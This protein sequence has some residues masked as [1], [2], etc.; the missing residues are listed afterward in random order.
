MRLTTVILRSLRYY[1]R[2]NV[3]V[4]LGAAVAVAVLVGSLVVGDSVNGS[5]R[6]LALERLGRVDHALTPPDYF[7]EQLAADLLAQASAGWALDTPVPAIVL[8]ATARH[9]ETDAIVPRVRVVGIRDDFVKLATGG[10]ESLLGLTGRHVVLND[11]LARAIGAAK[12]DALLVTIARRGAAPV[13]SIF[14]RRDRKATQKSLRVLVAAIIPTSGI[15]RFS[16]RRDEA[17]PRNLYIALPWLQRQ[18]KRRGQVNALLVAEPRTDGN[19]LSGPARAAA[20]RGTLRAAATADDL[21]L[22]VVAHRR[23]GYL[24]VESRRLT[25]PGAVVQALAP[26]RDH[27]VVSVYLANRISLVRDGAVV[28][29]VPYSVVAGLLPR[30]PE[31]IGPFAMS[32]GSAPPAALAP[33]DILLN[34]WAADRLEAKPGDVVELEYYVA[35]ENG[36][37]ATATRRFALRGVAKEEGLG[38]DPGLTP[39]FEGITDAKTMAEWD[40]P[41]PVDRNKIGPLDESY[42]EEHKAAPKAFLSLPDAARLWLGEA[43]P[44]ADTPAARALDGWVTSIPRPPGSAADLARA[45]DD[46]ADRLPDEL[47]LEALGFAFRPVRDQALAAA[48]GSTDFG[49]LFLSMSF[50][51]VAAGAA[52]VGLLMRLTVERRA[53][54]FGILLATGFT[55]RR[56]TGVLMGEGL[57]L[58]LLGT[59]LGAALGIG[60]AHGMLYAL[61]EWWTGAAGELTFSLHVRAATVLLG[62]LAGLAV[63]WLT[64]R[65]SARVLRRTRALT[66]L[67]GW[68][69][70]AAQPAERTRRVAR[71]VGA[72]GLVLAVLLLVL[73][74]GVGVVPNTAAFF[75]IGSLLLI[76]LLALLCDVLHH[77]TPAARGTPSLAR[78]ALRGM[79]RHWLRSALTVGL[80]AAASFLIVAVAAFRKDLRRLDT[81]RRDSGAGGFDLLGTS[82]VPLH[83]DLG[84]AEGR[85]ALGLAAYW[86]LEGCRVVSLRATSGDDASCLN[87]QRPAA[88]RVLGVPHNL[89]ERGGFSFTKHAP[90]RPAGDEEPNPWRLLERELPDGAVPALA[91][92]ATAQWILKVGLGD[93]IDVPNDRGGTV[94]LRLVGLLAGSIFQSQLLISEANF[95]KQFGSD[96]GYRLF[97]I[98]AE[99]DDPAAMP[100]VP[101]MP[102][103]ELLRKPLGELG[104]DVRSTADVLANYARVQNTYLSTFETLG[105]LGLLLG[106]FGTVAVLLRSVVERRGELA[107]ML[108]LGFRKRT[109]FATIVFE[110][111]LLLLLG[112]AIGTATALVAVAPHL[113]SAVADVRWGS[114]AATLAACVVV[115]LA[116]CAVAAHAATRGSLLDALRAE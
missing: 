14:G 72:W 102:L 110:N 23:R 15:G 104:I 33:G 116:A 78:L 90:L 16:L 88:P 65:W 94:R 57:V 21:G 18:L 54:Q 8:E 75:G 7:R 115:G 17:R 24:S 11:T 42:W 93:Q 59:V 20:L 86:P 97:L 114:L 62:S 81:H 50:F 13:S 2:S 69:A 38:V 61:R 34:G 40:P 58:A 92:A 60:Y 29:S 10:G 63:A 73:S 98:R 70:M 1:W 52:L 47:P 4:V 44:G 48:E 76:G 103:D 6:D 91:D 46:L 45:A 64:L 85:A 112:V 105:G 26:G 28:R 43:A 51:L 87:L 101:P 84:R 99:R 68:R 83:H 113:L 41:F 66:L 25:L 67:A 79:S 36:E 55:S 53:S 30:M 108:A 32:D 12:G 19:P 96:S 100:T 9:A 3:A 107:M 37:L 5:L 106:T 89:V 35:D 56:A 80:L 49:V 22:R 31:P 82:D 39:S 27:A 111:A 71:A 77:R 74:I 109:I 95:L